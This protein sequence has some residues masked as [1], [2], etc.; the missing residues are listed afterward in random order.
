MD[1]VTRPNE[2][3]YALRN[4]RDIFAIILEF[5]REDLDYSIIE[6][7]EGEIDL[8]NQLLDNAERRTIK[9]VMPSNDQVRATKASLAG[10]AI[11]HSKNQAKISS[12]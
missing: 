5:H 12:V 1:A 2:L 11:Q 6:L 9:V 3:L 4:S 8:Y 10:W 7:I